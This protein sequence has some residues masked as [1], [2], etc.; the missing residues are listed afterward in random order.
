MVQDSLLQSIDDFTVHISDSNDDIIQKHEERI[1][2]LEKKLKDIEYKEL[3]LWEKYTEEKMPKSVFDNL[4]T[5]YETERESTEKMLETAISTKPQRIDY[6]KHIATFHE[7]IECMNNENVSAETKNNLLRACIEKVSY[8]RVGAVRGS[9]E[10]AKE[11]QSY[12]RGW[13]QSE[14]HIDVT[15]RL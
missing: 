4:R 8:S 9:R 15:L 2:F 10:E 13:I 1:A 12:E 14:P 3:S 11:G 6:E 7:A 5:K